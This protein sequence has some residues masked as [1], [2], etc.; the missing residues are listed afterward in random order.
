VVKR[1]IPILTLAALA[2]AAWYLLKKRR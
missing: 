1:G 2:F